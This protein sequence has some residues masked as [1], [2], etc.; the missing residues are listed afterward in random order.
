[1]ANNIPGLTYRS[2]PA[3]FVRQ[4]TLGR[5]A[6]AAGGARIPCIMGEGEAEETVVE[7]ALGGGQDGVN[8]DFSG[9]NSPTGRHFQ[10]ST[11]GLVENRTRILLNGADLTVLEANIDTSAFDNRYD[12]RLERS[13]GR[14]ELQQAHLVSVGGT[15]AS[16][17]Y[18]SMSSTSPN[19]G[20]G[21]P[22]LTSSSLVDT[23]APAETWTIRCISVVK[24]G[25]GDRISGEATFSVS[26]ST[27]GIIKDANGN[28]YRWKSDGVTV[29]N[30]ILSF[31]IVE[32]SGLVFDVGDRFTV[33]VDSGVLEANDTLEARYIPTLS[34]NDP[35]LF[36]SPEDLFAK[37][38][39]PSSTNT[40]SLGAQMAFENGAPAVLALQAKPSVP[41][42]TA[43]TL[44]SPD[45]LLT[46]ATEGASG[47]ADIEDTIFPLSV[48][49][50]PDTDTT[51]NVYVLNPDGTESQLGLTKVDFYD[52]DYSTV[53]STY[54]GFVNSA[55]LSQSYTVVETEQVEQSGI[56]GYVISLDSLEISFTADSAAFT[57]DHLATGEGDV[58]KELHFL[59]PTGLAGASG[60]FAVY[61]ITEVGDGYGDT[62]Y[63]IAQRSSGPTL[64]GTEFFEDV[65]W[66]LVDPND[67]SVQFAVTDDVATNNLLS[68]KGLRIEYID[69]KDADFF[70]TNWGSAYEALETADCQIVVP[71]PTQTISNIFQAGRS[72][73]ET[74]SNV[75]NRKERTVLIGAIQGLDP[76]DL[77]GRTQA[78]VENIGVLEGIQG[79]DAEEVLEGNIEDLA[80]YSVT[81]AY[82][83]SFRTVYMAP[84]EIVR[85]INGTNTILAGYFMTPALAGF[86]A[87]QSNVAEPPTYKILTGF[88]ILR[89]KV[90]KQFTLDE[91][92]D[93]GVLVV[94]PVAGGGRM[95]HGLTTTQSGI[96][97]E[98][99]ISIVGIRDQVARALRNSMIPFIGTVQRSTTIAAITDTISSTLDALISQGLLTGKGAVSVS[100]DA[101]EPRQINVVVQV[102]PAAPI[103]WIFVDLTFAI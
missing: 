87:G 41:R 93:A 61:T 92:A 20:N 7:S 89:D 2:Q 71:L 12:V 77:V 64:T 8:S 40:L 83:T 96:P 39:R 45:N 21:Y 3:A 44:I 98:E 72:H 68:G 28:P 88:S 57:Q 4:N 99:E 67:T 62:S 55:T 81:A 76:D 97:E 78:A 47:N 58:G 42:K 22:V 14:I 23:S 80:D 30:G 86:L 32:G 70:D 38:G 66:H 52:T 63:V 11:I 25:V 33:E 35:E 27:S 90:Y 16:T 1:M 17:Q 94:Q 53:A 103:N 37:H 100:R 34:V 5:A 26:G 49:G 10:L 101:S 69:Q 48:D 31:S 79:D 24:D 36:L 59:D 60:S 102:S 15:G 29:S 9:T 54:S 85:N 13:T 18:Y 50:R 46:E 19:V 51:I 95:L 43:E 74:M 84:D 65:T 75:G 73:V 56:D 6:A 82:S 91:L